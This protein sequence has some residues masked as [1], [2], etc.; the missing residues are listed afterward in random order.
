VGVLG[1]RV[2]RLAAGAL[3]LLAVVLGLLALADAVDVRIAIGVGLLALLAAWARLLAL[4][5]ASWGRLRRLP[6]I[7]RAV[8]RGAGAVLLA[9]LALV[10]LNVVLHFVIDAFDLPRLPIGL[11]LGLAAIVFGAVVY[12]SLRGARYGKWPSGIAAAALALLVIVATPI[13]VGE[14]AA[15]SSAVPA[16]SEPVASKLD[17]LIV[18]A[19]RPRGIPREPPSDPSLA[20]FD[21]RYSVGVADG[22]GVRWTLVGG[23]DRGEALRAIA[24]GRARP[25]DAGAPLPRA[26][27]DPVLLLLVDGNPPVVETPAE[28]PSLPGEPGE[29]ERWKR[30]A[31]VAAPPPTPTFALL[32]TTAERR[33]GRWADRFEGRGEAVSIQALES[34]TATDAAA[35]LAVA[36]PTSR[37]DLTLATEYRPVLLFD[38]AEPDPWPLAIYPLFTEGRVSLCHD[39]NVTGTDCGDG[40]IRN[41]A[42]L[43]SGGTHL[44]LRL[45]SSRELRRLARDELAKQRREAAAEGAPVPEEG[46]AGA[47]PEGTPPPG[48]E[49]TGAPGPPPGAGTAIYVHPSSA[50]RDGRHLLYLDYWW[51]ISDNP[52]A[53][54]D[55]ALCGAGLVIAGVTCESHQ[56]DWEGMTV[57]VDRGRAEPRVLA[58]H[59]A[60][61]GDVVRYGW[62]ALRR[63]WDRSR[64]IAGLLA[65]V[66]DASARPLAFVAEGTHS[67][68]PIP[69]GDCSQVAHAELND[70]PHRGDFGWVGNDSGACGGASC[71]RP[72]PTHDAG[73]E[74]ALWNAFDGPWGEHH[75]Y[76]TYYCDSGSPPASP[77]HQGRYLHP[78]R[79]D[80]YVDE[81]WRFHRAPF[82]K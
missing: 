18:T 65:G 63:R 1:E 27:A 20:Q 49:P 43:E 5:A 15:E 36:A 76:L 31:A 73:R 82:E 2:K 57:V 78:A 28:L 42:E 34:T 81:S 9:L 64:K 72:L 59:Y 44:R 3:V 50:E 60:Q 10:G 56:S 47:A 12:W 25:G 48:T 22:D 77:G 39:L 33:L 58:V 17:L 75:C 29:V 24:A 35:R 67:T 4:L 55:G 79:Y 53:V 7:D 61:H 38:R 51:Y 45:R 68:Y 19:G 70:G 26:G 66:S 14:L 37:A 30:I 41:P 80:G 16:K 69:C 74:P 11:G 40:P 71:L 62:R 52:V 46:A 54:G 6:R 23:E 8:V 32:Q 21:V 13:L